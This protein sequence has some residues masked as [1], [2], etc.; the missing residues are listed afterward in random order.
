MG[1]SQSA[2]KAPW[3]VSMEYKHKDRVMPY[4]MEKLELSQVRFSVKRRVF[5]QICLLS[6]IGSSRTCREKQK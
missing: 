4:R 1:S 2:S 5:S 3:E 6:L